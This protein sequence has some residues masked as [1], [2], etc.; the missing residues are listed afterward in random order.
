MSS[1]FNLTFCIRHS[2]LEQM[3][4]RHT[5]RDFIVRSGSVIA[6]GLAAP[7]WL[8]HIARAELSQ[9]AGSGAAPRTDRVLVVCQLSGGNDGLNTV[10]P[11][12][13]GEYYDLRPGLAIPESQQV[14]LSPELSLHPGLAPLKP[15]YDSQQLAIV[16]GVGYPNHSRSH[17]AAMSIWQ[18]ADPTGHEKYGWL[19]RWLDAQ[20]AAGSANP[21][22]ALS[23]GNGRVEALQGSRASVPTFASLE[24][25][26]A[27]VGDAD[28]E[29]ALRAVQG[30]DSTG[31]RGHVKQATDT[32]LNA[33][34]ALVAR[35]DGYTPTGSYGEDQFGQ[36]F[37]QIAHLI[38]ISPGTRVIYF[39]VGGFDTH[40]EQAEKHAELLGQYAGALAAFMAEMQR[41]GLS[42]K[43]SVL[44][45]SEFGRRAAENGSAG[46]DHGAAAP[47]LLAGGAVAGGVHGEY[48]SLSD[49]DDGDLK[50]TCDFRSVYSSVINGWLDGDAGSVLGQEYAPVELFG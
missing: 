37:R 50:Y 30:T 14:A 13:V 39:A 46:T 10:I 11:H 24:D 43:V 28:A 16:N 29:R 45:F 34:D 44:T 22:L 27:M 2:T 4:D 21:V 5:R 3:M 26:R 40:A 19:G 8:S 18:T 25:V 17:F 1:E 35:L 47:V 23:F 42:D 48:P 38:A 12:T 36:G 33:M 6:V 31:S 20:A 9:L 32:A 49:L 7:A 41:L 15:L